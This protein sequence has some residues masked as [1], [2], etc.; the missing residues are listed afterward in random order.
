MQFEGEIQLDLR[1]T[2]FV[3]LILSYRSVSVRS[4]NPFPG[5]ASK[6]LMIF[7][8]LSIEDPK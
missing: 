6:E 3:M 8:R 5:V 4:Q 7:L 2:P 1:V